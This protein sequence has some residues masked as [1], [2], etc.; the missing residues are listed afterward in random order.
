MAIDL[1]VVDNHDSFTF[2]LVDYCRQLGA[3]V[4]VAQSDALSVDEALA[5]PGPLLLGPGPGHPADAGISVA[6]AAACIAAGK[7]LLGVCLGHQAI[8]LAAG[9]TIARAAPM[10]GKTDPITHDGGPLFAGL[11]SPVIMT[12][13]HSLVATDLPPTLT[14]TAHGSDGTIQALDHAHAPVHGIQFHPES[15][16]STHGLRLLGNFLALA[17]ATKL[18][19]TP[20]YVPYPFPVCSHPGP[21]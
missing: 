19:D 9:A 14:A 4:T 21:A 15:I 5:H 17:G 13:Y 16:A 1:L 11:P 20:A 8:A 18:L 12:R 7:H 6:L 10:H 3:T 2:T